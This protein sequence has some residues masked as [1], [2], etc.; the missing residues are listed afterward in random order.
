MDQIYNN[1]SWRC[2]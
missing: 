1:V 2:K